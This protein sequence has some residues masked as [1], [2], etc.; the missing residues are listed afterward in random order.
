MKMTKTANALLFFLLASVLSGAAHAQQAAQ[1]RRTRIVL[2]GTGTPNSDPDRMGPATAIVVD[3]TPYL[4]DAGPGIVRRAA[5][6]QKAG[7]GA[8]AAPRLAIVFITHLHSDHT[9]GL[10]DLIFSLWTLERTAPLAVYGPRGTKA[11][12]DHLSMAYAEDIKI[13]LD[14][15]E[16]SNR[17]GYRVEAHEIEPGVI[18]RDARVKVTAFAVPHGTW[19]D[20]YGYRFETPDRTIVISGDTRK[21][22]AIVDQCS[23]CDVLIHE[24]YSTSGF[25]RRPPEW[26]RYHSAFHTSAAELAEIATRAKPGLLI[27]YH[28]LFWSTSESDLVAEVTQGYSGRVVSGKDLEIY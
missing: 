17:T 16:P 4:V 18:Y 1:S 23:G 13:R 26:Q 5:A 7:V 19:Q 14:G 25:N 20:A 15:G 11:I 8:L 22:E 3:S 28:Q 12:T 2:L 27:L 24:V 9:L 21:A 6:A 10:P